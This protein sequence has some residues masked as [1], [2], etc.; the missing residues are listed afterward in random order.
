MST[1]SQE[2]QVDTLSLVCGVHTTHWVDSHGNERDDGDFWNKGVGESVEGYATIVACCRDVGCSDDVA[3]EALADFELDE[4]TIQ[5]ALVWADKVSNPWGEFPE[6]LE[7]Y[8]ERFRAWLL[9]RAAAEMPKSGGRRRLGTAP[10]SADWYC[11]EHLAPKMRHMVHAS[12]SGGKS[13]Y[14]EGMMVCSLLGLPFMGRYIAPLR[15]MVID[16]EQDWT[17]FEARALAWGLTDEH[18]ANVHMTTREDQPQLG[19]PRWDS[20]IRQAVSDFA[21]DVIVL[22]SIMASCANVGLSNPEI[23]ALFDNVLNPIVNSGPALLFTHHDSETGKGRNAG[24]GGVQW[25]G[26]V[27]FSYGVVPS[28]PLKKTL[29]SDGDFDTYSK[30]ALNFHKGNRGPYLIEEHTEFFEVTGVQR[31]DKSKALL[32]LRLDLPATEPTDDERYV[33]LL[34]IPLGRKVIA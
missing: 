29:R 13:L 19:T 1:V 20:W 25:S 24:L 21:P 26:Q 18:M 33:A 17:E 6:A 31:G 16:A 11:E 23:M 30:F 5:A 3:L 2:E 9:S 8:L 14:R 34:E 15:W 4:D 22:D 10:V 32:S 28:Q 12:W 27:D 7:P